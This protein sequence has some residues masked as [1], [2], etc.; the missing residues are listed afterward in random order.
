MKETK[1]NI[2]EFT[3]KNGEKQ[4]AVM[5][6]HEQTWQFTKYNRAFIRLLND[7]GSYKTNEDGKKLIGVELLSKLT[8]IGF[9]D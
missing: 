5:L 9:Q 2:V 4:K 3:N 8:Q 1:G 6:H 7:D